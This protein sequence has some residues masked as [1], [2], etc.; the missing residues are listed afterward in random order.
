M[1][2]LSVVFEN[3]DESKTFEWEITKDP[4]AQKWLDI[5]RNCPRATEDY[6]SDYDWWSVG[7]TEEHFNTIKERMKTVSS[8]LNAEN[9]FEIPLEWYENLNRENLNRLHKKFHEI[10]EN[11]SMPNLD[12][13]MLNYTVHVAESCLTNISNQTRTGYFVY[14]YNTFANIPLTEEDYQSFNCYNVKPGQLVLSYSTIGKNLYHCYVDNDMT[15][16]KSRM[17]RPKQTLTSSTSLYINGQY[18]PNE[19]AGFYKWCQDNQIDQYGYDYTAPEHTG[20]Q[21]IIG[22]PVGVWDEDSLINWVLNSDR[23]K[24]RR[25]SLID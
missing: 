20:G 21:C 14:F 13:N 7:H 11:L 3:Q 19:P 4:L 5:L 17:V 24:V 8:K 18:Q 9:G 10:A 6:N 12:V 2:I 15:I 22:N 16:I 25:W 23:V 1:T